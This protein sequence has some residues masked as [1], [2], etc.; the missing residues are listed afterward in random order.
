MKFEAGESVIV[1]DTENRPA[2]TGHVI[3]FDEGGLYRIAFTYINTEK[4]EEII[5][6]EHRLLSNRDVSDPELR[7]ADQI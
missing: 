7:I 5:L 2:G 1:L 3:S 4:K 6:P